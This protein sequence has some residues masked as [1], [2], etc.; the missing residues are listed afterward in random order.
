MVA[1]GLMLSILNMTSAIEVQK[2]KLYLILIY[3]TLYSHMWL[4]NTMHWKI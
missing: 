3:S 1:T 4:L 2:F